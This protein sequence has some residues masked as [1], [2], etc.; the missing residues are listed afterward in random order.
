MSRTIPGGVGLFALALTVVTS[1]P[2]LAGLLNT[3]DG[4][5][6]TGA[7][8]LPTGIA[9]D[10]HS[11]LAKIWQGRTGQF[12]YQL[13]FT[14]E[15]HPGL[16]LVQGFYVALGALSPLEPA[17]TYH[18]ARIV[19]TFGMVLAIYH[20]GARFFAL[21][22][23]RWL[24]LIFATLVSGASWLLLIIDPAQT[25]QIAPIEFWLIDAYNL[26]GALFMP[27]FAAAV[28]LQALA[29]LAFMD[30]RPLWLTLFL[31]LLAIL[32]PYVLVITAPLFVLVTLHT[33]AAQ[34]AGW[35]AVLWLILPLGVQMALTGYQ[36]VALQSDPV[37]QAFTAQNIT[38]SPPPV[39]YL[40]GYLPF[41]LPIALGGRGIAAQRSAL[42]LVIAW[43]LMISLFLYAPLPTQRRFLIGLQTPLAVLAVF[44]W[45]HWLRRVTP[46]RRALVA[47]IY[48]V[49]AGLP[50]AVLIG[51]NTI[52]RPVDVYYAPAERAGNAWLHENPPSG[53]ILTTFDSS[54]RGSGGRVVGATGMRVYAGHWIETA[55]FQTKIALLRQFYDP[56]ESDAW[57]W[58]FMRESGISHIWY[59]DYAR[60]QGAW[61]PAQ[62]PDLQRVFTSGG[63]HPVEIYRFIP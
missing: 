21:E 31:A 30:R 55:D 32:Q 63:D 16:P 48:V 28:G 4:H 43:V 14:H 47:V 53:V 58:Q 9:V 27:H 15:P 8:A 2:Y 23:E 36:F 46:S 37:W 26:A 11:H 12:A 13:L 20:F 7:A 45:R 56:A 19:F 17:L 54:G 33:M 10:Y 22:T 3:P 18:L 59:D 62:S 50:L 52:G 44:G 41:L 38:A 61:S 5:L 35:E 60:A 42:G 34:K 1:L 49:I 29:A 25:A 6:F 57:R 40:L 24:F 39:Y 51:A